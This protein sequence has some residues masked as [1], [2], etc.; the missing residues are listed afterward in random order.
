[1]RLILEKLKALQTAVEDLKGL[2]DL[3]TKARLSCFIG[4]SMLAYLI[5]SLDREKGME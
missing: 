4:L 3:A 2:D 1:M 5:T